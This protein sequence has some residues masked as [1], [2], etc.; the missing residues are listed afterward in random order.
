[1]LSRTGKMRSQLE[2]THVLG[3]SCEHSP[4]LELYTNFRSDQLQRLSVNSDRVT[5]TVV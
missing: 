3:A 1:M 4:T 2:N 5:L